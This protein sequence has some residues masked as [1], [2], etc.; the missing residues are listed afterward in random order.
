MRSLTITL[1]ALGAVVFAV[2]PALSQSAKPA[3][4]KAV[5]DEIATFAPGDLGPAVRA[6]A[7]SG[8]GNLAA[9]VRELREKNGGTPNPPAGP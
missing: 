3:N 6:E 8:A 7:T 1:V 2:T 9:A 5:A 4:P